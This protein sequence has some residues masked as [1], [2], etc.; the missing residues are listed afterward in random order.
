MKAVNSHFDG[1]QVFAVHDRAGAKETIL[2]FVFVEAIIANAQCLQCIDSRDFEMIHVFKVILSNLDR[3]HFFVLAQI[4]KTLLFEGA[5]VHNDGL[6]VGLVFQRIF[7]HFVPPV[8][9]IAELFLDSVIPSS[10]L[11]GD[12]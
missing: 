7:S 11:V 9:Q 12:P 5:R 2:P 6:R 3:N 8:D 1:S 4:E 10:L